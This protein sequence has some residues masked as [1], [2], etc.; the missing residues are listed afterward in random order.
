MKRINLKILTV[1]PL[2]H[3]SEITI[4]FP[5]VAR[6]VV[7]SYVDK[8][9]KTYNRLF[10][11]IFV[12][13]CHNGGHSVELFLV[14]SRSIRLYFDFFVFYRDSM[15]RLRDFLHV[16]LVLNHYLTSLAK[17]DIAFPAVGSGSFNIL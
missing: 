1:L 10:F 8:V 17:I 16:M 7:H 12:N 15:N 5:F 6:C 4:R 11:L 14:W 13:C 9:G 3:R 2:L